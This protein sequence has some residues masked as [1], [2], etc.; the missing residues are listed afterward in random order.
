MKGK[1]PRRVP[2]ILPLIGHGNDIGVVKMFP[3]VISTTNPLSRRF[4]RRRIT[5]Q[6][7]LDHVVIE[8]LGPKHAGE[9]LA[10]DQ[11]RV[12]RKMF[13]NDGLIELIS[14]VKA[15]AEDLFKIEESLLSLVVIVIG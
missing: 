2:W 4:G 7:L 13:G 14:L 1:I 15:T 5:I 11:P 6:P 12:V 10:H 9:C 8:L 3:L